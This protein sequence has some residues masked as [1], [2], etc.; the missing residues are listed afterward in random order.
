MK[1][2]CRICGENNKLSF[3]H[4]PPES[5]LN[6]KPV[7]IQKSEHL[8]DKNSFV[9]GKRI[10]SNRGAGSYSLCISCNNITGGNY[11]NSFKKF[12]NQGFVG[13]RNR[14]WTNSLIPFVFSI[15]PLNVLKQ[16][17]TMF[18]S[19]DKSN[20]LLNS[21]GLSEFILNKESKS[22]PSKL[23]IFLYYTDSISV[24]NGCGFLSNLGSGILVETGE[25][26]FRPFGYIYTIDSLPFAK[27]AIEIT[28]WNRFKYNEKKKLGLHLPFLMPQGYIPGLYK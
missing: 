5:A 22:M 20:R 11:G 16:I 12:V 23:R 1:G 17:L 18:M 14:V 10:L 3:E 6:D 24:R 21:K 25:I 19:I 8:H 28:N 7:F 15:E 13:C 26:T 4:T 2:I 27:N 9:Y